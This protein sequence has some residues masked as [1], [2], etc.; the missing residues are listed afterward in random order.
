MPYADFQ[1]L[2]T[3]LVRDDAGVVAAVDRDGAIDLAAVRYSTDRPQL[4]VEDVA[5]AGG[6]A[7]ALPP[8]WE[9][10]FSELIAIE[11]PIGE[12]PPT[13]LERESFRLYLKPDGTQELR[14]DDALPNAA[15]RVAYTVKQVLTAGAQGTDTIPL[16][17]R[18]AVC[19]Y[20]AS[21]LCDQLAANYSNSTG[22]T[23]QADAVNYQT[24]A[25]EYRKQAS[26]YR[27]QYLAHLGIDEKKSNPAA[28]SAQVSLRDSVG[29]QRFF[30]GRSRLH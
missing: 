6:N 9:V 23:I 27:A 5:A 19:K 13:Y 8:A 12:N 18:E 16:T 20:A 11:Y 29:G 10:D 14:F 24:K 4:K 26:G 7:L 3:K 21:L 17:D 1:T 30:H 2:V 22:S 25:S 28:V 15:V